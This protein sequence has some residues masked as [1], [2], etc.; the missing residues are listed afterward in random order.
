MLNR[1]TNLNYFK[2]YDIVLGD[3]EDSSLVHLDD[4]NKERNT[5]VHTY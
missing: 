5:I 2:W 3:P 1:I 4:L